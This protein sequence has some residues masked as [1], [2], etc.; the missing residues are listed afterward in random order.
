M[1]Q[2][3]QNEGLRHV[4]TV[5]SNLSGA[6]PVGRWYW[7]STWP[8]PLTLRMKTELSGEQYSVDGC[9]RRHRCQ[10]KFQPHSK[11]WRKGCFLEQHGKE[12]QNGSQLAPHTF[13]WVQSQNHRHNVMKNALLVS[14]KQSMQ[15]SVLRGLTPGLTQV[16]GKCAFTLTGPRSQHGRAAVVTSQVV[17]VS[18]SLPRPQRPGWEQKERMP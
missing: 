5:K 9:S 10:A 11:D 16:T 18:Q 3:S 2:K 1:L 14:E 4:L 13:L 12:Q 6:P 8:H 7:R 15:S 17:V